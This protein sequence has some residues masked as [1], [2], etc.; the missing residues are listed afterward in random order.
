M[1]LASVTAV[2]TVSSY[3][4]AT[5]AAP[6]FARKATSTLDAQVCVASSANLCEFMT[7]Q[8]CCDLGA[9]FGLYGIGV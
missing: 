1:H 5:T 8:S 2:Q 3:A 7:F 9:P 4:P 6:I